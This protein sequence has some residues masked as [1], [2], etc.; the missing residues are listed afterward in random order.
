MAPMMKMLARSFMM[1]EV[2]VMN[3]E[4]NAFRRVME[5]EQRG[6]SLRSDFVVG[7]ASP[8]DMKS[9]EDVARSFI[10]RDGSM[11]SL[12][13]KDSSLRFVPSENADTFAFYP[14]EFKVEV[15]LSWFANEKYT[16]DELDFANHHEIAH[17]IDMRKNPQAFIDGFENMEQEARRLANDYLASHPNSASFDAVKNFFYREI[18]SLYNCLDDIY[19]NNVVFARNPFFDRGDGREAVRSLYEKIGFSEANLTEQPLHHQFIY[20]LLRDEMLGDTHGESIVDSRVEAVFRKKKLGV[21]LRSLID[22]KLKPRGGILKDPGE[23]YIIIQTLILPEYLD[24]LTV[25]LD[26]QQKKIQNTE[27]GQSDDFN[28]FHEEDDSR[29]STDILDHG[30][31]SEQTT[32]DVLRSFKEAD[33]VSQMSPDE[34]AEYQ[35]K[36]GMREFDQEHGITNEQ[37]RINEQIKLE[38]EDARRKMRGFWRRLIGKS[39]E[40]R[41]TLIKRQRRGRLSIE[42][43]IRDYSEIINSQ[44]N[45]NLRSLEIYE[46][47]GVER[48]IVDQ[49][50]SIEIT[51]LV[52]CSGSMDDS[53]VRAARKAAALLMYSIKDFNGELEAKRRETRSK[54]KVDTEVIVFG[55]DYEETKSFDRANDRDTNDAEIIKTIS[56]I[57]GNRNRTDNE[58]PLGSIL[59][60]LTTE[61]KSRIKKKKLKKIVFEITDG[62]PDDYRKVNNASSCK[63]AERLSQLAGEGVIVIGFQI[64]NVNDREREAFEWI[65][66][67]QGENPNKKGIFIGSDISKLPDSL[68]SSLSEQL[69]DIV[70]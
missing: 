63:T 61:M 46:R 24:L 35:R 28:P 32:K 66:N 7:P 25:A 17:F 67:G 64:G 57:D 18:H 40:Y 14:K 45:G 54:L 42:S 65:W 41:P 30:E 8:D 23:R 22:S 6:G 59:S 5:E 60:K 39:I 49:P 47:N 4:S 36:K 15:P 44:R 26:E 48:R 34:R 55:S 62:M 51:L 21:S 3:G 9:Q 68:M 29:A 12:F 1:V 58:S 31:N 20:A 38:I 56:I 53:K 2:K 33:D 13:A 37:R 50:E 43:F 69:N 27:S 11:L 19:V 16:E 52:D 10:R 70:I